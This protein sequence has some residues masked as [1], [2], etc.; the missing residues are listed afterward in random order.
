VGQP[1][2]APPTPARSLHFMHGLIP[3]G[4]LFTALILASLFGD[5]KNHRM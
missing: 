1:K 5:H 2:A 4:M 3:L